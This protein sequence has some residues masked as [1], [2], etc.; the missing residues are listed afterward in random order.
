MLLSCS[1]PGWLSIARPRPIRRLSGLEDDHHGLDQKV[2]DIRRGSVGG[3]DAQDVALLQHAGMEEHDVPVPRPERSAI[4]RRF[5]SWPEDPGGGVEARRDAAE[6]GLAV[7]LEAL[8]HRR[9][10]RRCD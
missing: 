4:L 2:V 8:S 6:D 1:T 5:R 9:S 7:D 3:A 10:E